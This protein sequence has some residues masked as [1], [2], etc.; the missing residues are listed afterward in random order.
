MTTGTRRST[1]K[2]TLVL[3]I[4]SA[5]GPLSIDMYLPGLPAITRDFGADTAGTQLTLSLFFLGMAFGQLFYGPLADRFGR[6]MPLLIGSSVYALASLGCALAPSLG[7]LIG[8]R[9]LQALGGCAGMVI[10]R[11]VVRDLFDA[12]E[13]A[14][15]YSFL[16]L[17][18]G[19]APITAPLIGGQILL[20]FGWR[21][22]FWLLAFFGIACVLLV[23]FGLP[24]TLP[25]E[26]RVS[27]GPLQALR[28]YGRILTDRRFV[29]YALTSGCVAAGMFAYISGS[30]FVII[31]LYGVAPEHYGLIF[32][33]NAF[34]LIMASQIN[35]RLLQRFPGD[36]IQAIALG[37]I[38]TSGVVLVLVAGSGLGGLPGL[39]VPLFICIAGYGLVSPNATAAAMAPHGSAAGSASALLGSLQ[40][41]VGAAAGTLVG[42]LYNSTALPMAAVIAVCLVCG[43]TS[44]ALLAQ[45]RRA[46][47]E[48]A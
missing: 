30:P 25:P 3:G 29:G 14:R 7:S 27:T 46:A 35:R 8:L 26:R 4:L 1:A 43:A 45:P 15:M 6:R 18:M 10:T 34:G 31:E 37:T 17:V 41:I 32:G 33:A 28:I 2:L 39:L 38:V 48:A 36:T 47:A 9:L 11:S 24:E 13:S 20:F 23:W 40:F 16:M 21:G 5:F 12:R 42:V 22:I 19:L 44:F